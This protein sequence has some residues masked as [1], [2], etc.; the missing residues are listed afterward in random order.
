MTDYPFQLVNYNRGKPLE[1]KSVL[2]RRPFTRYS[3]SFAEDSRRRI[4]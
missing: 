1:D 3:T 2:F 4:A